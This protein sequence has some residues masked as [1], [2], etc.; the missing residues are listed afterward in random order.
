MVVIIAILV[1]VAV[2]YQKAVTHLAKIKTVIMKHINP[3][4]QILIVP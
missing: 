1:A 4:E 3:K 2:S